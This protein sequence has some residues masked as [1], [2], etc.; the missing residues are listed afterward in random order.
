MKTAKKALCIIMVL[1]V[2][3]S[4]VCFSASAVSRPPYNG[5]TYNVYGQAVAAPVGYVP[6]EKITY[7]DMGTT[8]LKSPSDM[9]I[10]NDG[11]QDLIFITDTGNNRIVVLDSNYKFIKEIKQFTDAD[12]KVYELCSPKG[13]FVFED[14]IYVTNTRVKLNE[15]GD[16][17]TDGDILIG[18]MDGN[19]VDQFFKPVA[20]TVDIT[21]FDPLSVV[22]DKSGYVY[23]RAYGVLDGLIV[24]DMEGEFV[25]FFGAN[26]VEL[27]FDIIVQRIWKSIF[28]REAADQ[29]LKAVPTEMSNIFVD[30]EG[31]IYT[32]TESTA[33]DESLR[34]RKLNASG[35]NILSSDPNALVD[36]IFGDRNIAYIVSTTLSTRLVDVHVDS[37]D[38]IAALDARRGRVFLYDQNS[39]LLTIFGAQ[40]TQFGATEVAV[41]L[42]KVD[43]NYVILDQYDGSLTTYAPTEFMEKLLIADTYYMTGHYIEG[44]PYWR[45]VLLY[46][47]NNSRAYA[48][49]GKSLLE[50]E[51]YEE[52][53]EYLELGEDRTSY[54]K[55]LAEYRT[56]YLRDNWM[57]L[58]PVVVV[59]VVVIMYLYR[60][61]RKALGLKNEKK[62]VKF[63]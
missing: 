27:T 41:A 53:L 28:S 10:Y 18:D 54:S 51:K 55:A 14:T 12:G 47:A 23:V 17:Y 15:K 24:Y 5:Y 25:S 35:D 20:A 34:I 46:D 3:M 60:L 37:N 8:A 62:K 58:L 40:G 11:E 48:A 13:I 49:I 9:F 38:I 7:Q 2:L 63:N 30:E 32:S 26:P 42:G 57:W 1:L 52:S 56:Q 61:I 31:F 59:A 33:V 6:D 44:E 50:Q 39:Y 22:V 43:E 29:L 21:H 36:T 19:F 4:C 16:S 45:T